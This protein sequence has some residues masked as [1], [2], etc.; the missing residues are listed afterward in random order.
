VN[1]DAASIALQANNAERALHHLDDLPSND[2]MVNCLN[3]QSAIMLND[4]RGA[5][6]AWRRT[7]GSC[8]EK[9]EYY[10][11]VVQHYWDSNDR[12]AA[13][14]TLEEWIDFNE[15]NPQPYLQL[16]ILHA[17]T[18]PEE[19]VA[20]LRKAQQLSDESIPIASALIRAIEEGRSA[21]SLA[22]SLTSIGQ[23][24]TQNSVWTSAIWAFEEALT[25]NPEFAEAHAYLGLALDQSGQNGYT[26]LEN[27]IAIS[28]ENTLGYIFMAYHWQLNEEPE[29]AKVYLDEAAHL[30]PTNPA[31]RAELAQ[32]Y[33]D[34][35]DLQAAKA[36]LELTLTLAPEDPQFWYLLAQFSIERGI[37]LETLGIPAARNAFLL[38]R[39][40][41]L[42]LV[43][44]GN[45]HLVLG[46]IELA[47]RLLW[48]AVRIDPNIAMTQFYLGL[49]RYIQDD[50]ERA[51]AAWELA[52]R[53]DP[54]GSIG[55]L[56]HR[57]I[58][59][60]ENSP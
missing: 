32:V 18:R 39:D 37:E 24:L 44:L 20:P 12:P 42:G 57:M 34:L 35:G 3:V 9:E 29:T 43:L 46:N 31:I 53:L 21:N 55:E 14:A 41:P 17:V 27:A 49:L 45:A 19:A 15:E 40:N 47:E 38:D 22:Y 16:G 54:D 5:Q 33:I 26:Y 25:Y 60:I 23:V 52:L 51:Q 1:L 50:Y 48:R 2:T 4:I 10:R 30:D 36:A 56:S 7:N 13:L 8:T 28:P 6:Q 11:A 59:T 58:Q